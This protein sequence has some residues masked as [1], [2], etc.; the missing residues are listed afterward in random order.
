M[1]Y[2]E[3]QRTLVSQVAGAAK[4]EGVYVCLCG[5][6]RRVYDNFCIN[7]RRWLARSAAGDECILKLI[8]AVTNCLVD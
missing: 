7:Q 4:C 5:D 8:A 2:T 1:V 6:A 3:S